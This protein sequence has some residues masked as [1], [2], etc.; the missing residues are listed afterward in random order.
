VL[1][2]DLGSMEA[3]L[4]RTA[5]NAGS[6]LGINLSAVTYYAAEQPFLNIFRTSGVARTSLQG[7]VTG[8][9]AAGVYDTHEEAYL[10]LDADGY[11]TSLAASP[12]D[13][14]KPQLFDQLGVLLLAGLSGSNAGTGP[15]YR[16]GEYVVLYDGQGKIVYTDGATLVRSRPGRDLIQV[17][18]PTGGIGINIVATDPDHTGNYI[19]NIRVVYARYEKLLQSGAIFRPDFLASLRNFRVLRFMDWLGTNNSTLRNWAD[20]PHVTDAAYGTPL[21]VPLE[22][23]LALANTVDADPWVNVPIQATDEYV[24]QMAVQV[25]RMLRPDLDVYVELSN[26]VWNTMFQQ[27]RYAAAQGKDLWP[28]KADSDYTDSI[29]WYG[30]RTAQ[31]CDIWKS[32]WGNDSSRVHCVLGAQDANNWTATE[33]LDCPLWTGA[34]NAPCYKHGI[35]AVAVA[36]YFGFQA[37]GTWSSESLPRQLDDLFAELNHGG[38]IA[39]DY[40]GGWLKELADREAAYSKA[41]APYGLPLITYEGG[42]SFVTAPDYANGSWAQTLYIAANRDP[43]MGAA[44]LTALSDWKAGGGELYMQFADVAA[45]GQY[46][47]WGALESY[48]DT[49]S[50]L[51]SAPPKWQALQSFIAHDPCWWPNCRGKPVASGGG[52]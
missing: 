10:R 24:T 50:P 26:E 4:G 35:A 44:Y 36:P 7:W 15:R 1:L 29:D 43:R 32:V 3:A 23:C 19:R 13:P 46:G 34:G 14:H 2:V 20:R 51:S 49:I 6:P 40:P 47:E 27:S 52:K 17:A 45:P 12:A 22:V 48:L 37:P 11:P 28:G 21:G 38:L 5:A 16:P 9:N 30:M 42:Q 8:S 25:H 41:L 39:G 33:A 18:N 31:M